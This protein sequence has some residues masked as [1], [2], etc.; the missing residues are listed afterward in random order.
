MLQ[1]FTAPTITEHHRTL[2][3]TYE[4]WKQVTPKVDQTLTR[5]IEQQLYRN[6][7]QKLIRIDMSI[8]NAE[9]ILEAARQL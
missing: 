6:K 7:S 4:T 3:A 2:L 1:I 5:L 9:K 8:E